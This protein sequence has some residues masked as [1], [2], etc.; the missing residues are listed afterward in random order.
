V[1]KQLLKKNGY[2]S[3]QLAQ[4]FFGMS[5]GERIP[6]ITDFCERFQTGRGTVQAAL[7]RMEERGAIRLESRGH[8]GT[9]LADVDL[10]KLWELT[11]KQTLMGTMPLPYSKRYEGLA[12]GLYTAFEDRNLPFHLAYMR[13]AA[14]RLYGLVNRRY[15]FAIMS[16]FSAEK[17]ISENGEI[18]VVQNFGPGSYLGAHALLF[19]DQEATDIQDGMKVGVDPD[20]ID[21]WE[22]TQ[23]ACEGKNVALI[24]LPYSQI[25]TKLQ[26]GKIDTCIFNSDEIADRYIQIKQVPINESGARK[27]T[28]A[29]IVIRSEDLYFFENLFKLI[30]T[31]QIQYIQSQVIKDEIPPKY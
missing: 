30:D 29:V 25:L 9:Y 18:A 2:V 1:I 22:L 16:R 13:G 14:N 31:R 5:K 24:K 11:E 17:T 8:Q 4:L 21:Q 7:K 26:D 27:S 23:Q 6:R 10:I 28:E 12:T 20:S 19:L 15:D 3:M